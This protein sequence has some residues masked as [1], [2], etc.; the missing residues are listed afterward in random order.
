M[1][2]DISLAAR[3]ATPSDVAT[4]VSLYRQLEVEQSALKDMWPL[5]DGLA[6]PVE[7][8]A[9]QAIDDPD[10]V[11]VIGE[12]EAVPFGF[13][14]A[15]IEELL[16][17]AGGARV[18]AIRLIFTEHEARGVG[19]GETMIGFTLEQLRKQG[20]ERFDAHVLPG[21][22]HAKNFFEASGFAARS[23]IMHHRDG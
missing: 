22:R 3:L 1:P 16:P 23:I 15:R 21:H 18:G 20:L 5:A 14:L 11:V 4:V 6:E 9:L 2:D 12:A 10:S 13:V 17:Q 8:S 7:D 19:I